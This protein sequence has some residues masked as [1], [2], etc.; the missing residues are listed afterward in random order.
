M[1]LNIIRDPACKKKSNDSALA[2]WWEE[3]RIECITREWETHGGCLWRVADMSQA[4]VVSDAGRRALLQRDTHGVCPQRSSEMESK[5][6]EEERRGGE[7]MEERRGRERERE[8]ERE[9][10]DG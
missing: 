9:E 2:A 6:G 5:G 7:E 8:R 1:S 4:E 10:V 3:G